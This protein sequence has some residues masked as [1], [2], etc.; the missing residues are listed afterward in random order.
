MR[1]KKK[2]ATSRFWQVLRYTI[3]YGAGMGAHSLCA[4]NEE[5]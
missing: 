3:P 4:K 5:I 2:N 1:E